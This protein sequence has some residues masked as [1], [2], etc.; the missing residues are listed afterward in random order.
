[1][2]V[3]QAIHAAG[4]SSPGNMRPGTHAIALAARDSAHLAEI[5]KRLE[6]ASIPFVRVVEDGPPYVGELLA[7]GVRPGP[8]S[9]V[10]R[11]LSDLP[12][13]RERGLPLAP[14]IDEEADRV[15]DALVRRRI[16]PASE[17]RPIQRSLLR[18][19]G[20]FLGGS[21]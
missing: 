13:V 15:I 14:P 2:M 11:P 8:K 9:V 18:R 7:I 21:S 5:A 1:M 19:I 6:N 4:E 20:D 17:T 12:L 16:A 10:G 3:A